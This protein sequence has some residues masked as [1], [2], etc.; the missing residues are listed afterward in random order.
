M[1]KRSDT[2][3]MKCTKCKNYYITWDK[4]YPHGCRAMNFKSKEIPSVVVFK[5]SGFQCQLFREKKKP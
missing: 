3:Y 1:Q 5:N 4:N 2:I